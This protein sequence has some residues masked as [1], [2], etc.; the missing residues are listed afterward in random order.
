MKDAMQVG[1]LMTCDMIQG[2]ISDNLK[3]QCKHSRSNADILRDIPEH[4][5]ITHKLSKVIYDI[6]HN[7]EDSTLSG[8]L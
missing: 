1:Q 5:R 8:R 3:R 2:S 4:V 6:Q 7:S